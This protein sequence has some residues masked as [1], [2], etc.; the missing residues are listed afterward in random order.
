VS[1]GPE[2]QVDLQALEQER[3]RLSQRL[4]EVAKLSEGNVPAATFYGEMLKKLL[5][6]LAA[7]AGAVWTRTAQGNLQLQFQI[8]M[9]EVGLDR[10]DETRTSHEELL[11]RVVT[12][13]RPLHLPPH[14]GVGPAADGRPP[15]ANNSDLLLLLVPILLNEQAGG[16]VEVWQHANRPQAATRGF[17]QFMALMADLA[18]RYQRNQIMGQLT[19]QQQLWVQLE[20]FSR[21]I[22][23]SL[24]PTEVGYLVANDGRRLIECDR[25]SVAARM[26]RRCKVV[27]VSGAESVETRSA[28]VQRMRKLSDAVLAWD[29]KLTFNGVRDDGLPPKVLKAL[30]AYL[31]V[32]A[33]KL[34]VLQPLRDDREGKDPKKPARAALLMECFEPPADVQQ[35]TA[36]MDVIS[37]HAAPALYNAVEHRR[38]PMRWV[39]GP[40]ARVQEGIG[41]KGRAISA[42]VVVALSL[43]IACLVLIPYPL[44]MDAKGEL[45]PEDRRV[46]Y[47][48]VPGRVERFDV[49]PGDVVREGQNLARLY[50]I[51]LEKKLRQ[52]QLEKD[53][54]GHEAAENE[55]LTTR[56]TDLPNIERVKFTVEASKQRLIEASKR[57]EI[58]ELVNRTGAVRE[59][60]GIFDLRAPPFSPQ[61]A[62]SIRRRNGRVEWTVLNGN[63]REDW[64]N[65]LAQPSDALLRLGAKDG[66]WEIELK[67]PQKHIGQV[68]AG[69]DRLPKDAPKVL[70]VDFLL[71]SDP[72]LTYKGKLYRDRIAGEATPNKDDNN[73]NEPYVLAY[74]RVDDPSIDPAYRL[75]QGSLVS[76]T[77]VH[78][79]VR[80][81]NHRLGYALFY[82]VW[83][84]LYEKVVFFF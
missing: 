76:G 47:S 74:V 61:E 5:E 31:E 45:L 34:L 48:T 17:L 44:K 43:L 37:R 70:D 27:A 81:G 56:R 32:S 59:E 16:V 15:A 22:H 13:P 26:G 73:E 58:D 71:R 24:N 46:L 51:D 55:N 12:E 62:D 80:C 52:L 39:W 30:D 72:T 1:A 82:G 11:R 14:S 38:I 2:P 57:A 79:K 33:S 20:S 64:T 7:P 67:I 10:S 54:A 65:R 42:L 49:V 40:L 6:S 63:F 69:F 8:N 4:E 53:S 50:D 3:R 66:P 25:V 21:S 23:G 28:L 29:E 41:G 36:R 84:F 60:P 77:E 83:E 9:R 68:L 35:L 78:A 75:P 19:G 18:A